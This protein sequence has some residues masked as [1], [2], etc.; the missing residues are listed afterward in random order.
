MIELT[1]SL[2]LS[3]LPELR[4]AACRLREFGYGLAIDDVGPD[5]RDHSALL[6]LPFSMMKLDKNVVQDA[7]NI[8]EARDFLVSAIA[9]AAAA[10][11]TVIAEGIE[12]EATWS[13]MRDL[14]ADIA[15]GFLVG[16]PLRAAAVP[17]WHR[18]WCAQHQC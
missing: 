18:N 13:Q 8:R 10:G 12:N 3:R 6:D 15:Q 11:L 2:P 16:R 7:G 1:E 9:D 5:I 14:G 17:A 4:S